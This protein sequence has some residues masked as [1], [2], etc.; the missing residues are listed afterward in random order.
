MWNRNFSGTSESERC[1]LPHLL[2][3]SSTWSPAHLHGLCLPIQPADTA[4]C[5][6]LAAEHRCQARRCGRTRHAALGQGWVCMQ[7][8]C[9]RD[10]SPQEGQERSIWHPPPCPSNSASHIR[11]VSSHRELGSP[12]SPCPGLCAVPPGWYPGPPSPRPAP[13]TTPSLIST[14]TRKAWAPAAPKGRQL[15][16]ASAVL[17]CHRENK[18]ES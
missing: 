3:P 5:P 11:L 7:H 12:T 9:F 10:H 18:A 8:L 1:S 6:A 4:P 14:Q 15:Q 16:A 17:R 2:L 13:C